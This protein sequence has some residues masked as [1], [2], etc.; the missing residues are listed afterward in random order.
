[1]KANDGYLKWLSCPTF[2]SESVPSFH[3]PASEWSGACLAWGTSIQRGNLANLTHTA[4]HFLFH[5]F[6]YCPKSMNRWVYDILSKYQTIHCIMLCYAMLCYATLCYAML[7]YAMLCYAMLR[8]AMLRCAV[9]C[10]A[11][12]CYAMLCY[13]LLRY[14]TIRYATIRKLRYDTLRY[15]TIWYDMVPCS[16]ILCYALMWWY[17]VIRYNVML[18]WCDMT[19]R[20]NKRMQ[21]TEMPSSTLKLYLLEWTTF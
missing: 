15:D 21:Y 7:C 3:P 2:A 14:A 4:N 20:L 9:L 17:D 10:C 16:A 1:M 8:C 18:M 11:V 6:L 13:A 19:L 5:W 12:L